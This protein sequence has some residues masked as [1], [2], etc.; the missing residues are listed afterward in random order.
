MAERLTVCVV[1]LGKGMFL[2]RAYAQMDDVR[3]YVADLDED[4]RRAAREELG[5][6]IEAEL[7]SLDEALERDDVDV[8]VASLPHDMHAEAARRA[9]EAGKHFATEKPIAR[10]LEEADAMI[11]AFEGTGLTFLVMENQALLPALRASEELLAQGAVGRPWWIR[12]AGAGYARFGGWRWSAERC[13]G[14]VLIDSG[15]HYVRIMRRLG[16]E[17][18]RIY[19]KL[20]YAG[21]P[22]MEGED[23][24]LVVWEWED[25]FGDLLASWG[26]R[27]S[28]N[29]YT[30]I[31]Y[32]TDGTL[33][34][35]GQGLWLH[36]PHVPGHEEGL[37]KVE[38][39]PG[40][41]ASVDESFRLEAREIVDAVREGRTE[42]P[43]SPLEA[44]RDLEIVLAAYRSAREG[45]PVEV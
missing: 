43:L 23:T 3:L 27:H 33:I 4:R 6:A 16:G 39:V 40:Y 26:V 22:D 44:R 19:A 24:A 25:C 20:G 42:T 35:D 34:V 41:A 12:Y 45:Q 31:V 2:A 21:H 32:G 14:G 15:I 8:I 30:W 1:G 28:R 36:S 18:R 7:S 17:P 13:G 10:T 9:A 11:E 37:A 5:E 38:G 29:S